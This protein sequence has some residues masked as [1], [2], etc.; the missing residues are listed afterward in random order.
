VRR[1]AFPDN[2]IQA[3]SGQFELDLD[4]DAATATPKVRSV[5]IKVRRTARKA[6]THRT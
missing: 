5:G 1:R 3:L 2:G 4:R 6:V